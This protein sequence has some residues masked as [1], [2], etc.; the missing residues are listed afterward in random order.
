MKVTYL[1]IFLQVTA[2]SNSDSE[3]RSS[4]VKLEGQV[5][6]SIDAVNKAESIE[7]TDGFFDP[8][9]AFVPASTRLYRLTKPQLVNTVNSVMSSDIKLSVLGSDPSIGGYRNNADPL[10]FLVEMIS[11]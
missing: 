10:D 2:C 4:R 11:T 5:V 8:K 9:V 1:M 7:D 3:F 6:G